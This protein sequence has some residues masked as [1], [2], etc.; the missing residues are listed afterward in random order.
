MASRFNT[1]TGDIRSSVVM[2]LWFATAFSAFVLVMAVLRGSTKYEDLGGL[3]TW[4]IVAFYYV[5]GAVGGIVHGL[6][7]P[8][9]SRYL[10]KYLTAYLLLFLVY[11][12][13]TIAFFPMI[14]V[15]APRVPLRLLLTVWAFLCLVLAPIY[16]K[17]FDD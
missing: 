17:M 6:L 14:N 12:G 9:R 13:G 11:G 10:G 3:R 1:D 5:A 8:T 7:K 16:V 4:Q 2:G 15:E